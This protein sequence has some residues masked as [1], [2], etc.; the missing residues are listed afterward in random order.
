MG[1]R[2]GGEE[3]KQSG[4][5]RFRYMVEGLSGTLDESIGMSV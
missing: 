1:G 4:T 3:K 5:V 2:G